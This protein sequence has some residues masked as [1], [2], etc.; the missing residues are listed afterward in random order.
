MRPPK[1]KVDYEKIKTDDFVLGTIEDVLYDM[2]HTF[3]GFQGAPDKVQA[4]IRLVF[5]VDGYKFP[6]KSPWM[7][8]SYSSKSNI[9]K[10]YISSLVEGATEFMDFDI[11]QIKGMRVKMLWADN[12]D[13]QGIETIRP[14]DKKIIPIITGEEPIFNDPNDVTEEA[15]F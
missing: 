8:F 6:H 10:K 13:F 3:K 5:S 12:G 14:L 9:F 2:E 11:D 15:P 1:Q 7:K 4:G